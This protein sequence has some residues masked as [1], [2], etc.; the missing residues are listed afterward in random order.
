MTEDLV[1]V[2]KEEGVVYNKQTNKGDEIV[3]KYLLNE[4]DPVWLGSR[5]LYFPL[6]N[7]FVVKEFRSF[8]QTNTNAKFQTRDRGGGGGNKDLEEYQEIMKGNR[9]YEQLSDRYGLH[10]GVLG[11]IGRV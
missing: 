4:D 5:F 3:E 7:E 10:M 6:A 2:D 1:G 9:E 11:S 8:M